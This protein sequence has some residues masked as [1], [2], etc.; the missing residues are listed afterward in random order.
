MP[1][2]LPAA[3]LYGPPPPRHSICGEQGLD[4]K[5]WFPIHYAFRIP[6]ASLFANMIESHPRAVEERINGYTPYLAYML[7]GL[8]STSTETIEDGEL[9]QQLLDLLDFEGNNDKQEPIVEE[10]TPIVQTDIDLN[11]DKEIV[12]EIVEEEPPPEEEVVD[13]EVVEEEPPP[14][15]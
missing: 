4:H 3:P 2:L 9:K 1:T 15:E 6:D 13:E 11:T 12:E 14:E 7:M 5:G 8:P 10:P